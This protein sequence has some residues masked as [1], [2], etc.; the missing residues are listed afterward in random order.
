MAISEAC[1]VIER[2]A[3]IETAFLMHFVNE[4]MPG[5]MDRLRPEQ[6]EHTLRLIAAMS[7]AIDVARKV[8]ALSP[9][10]RELLGVKP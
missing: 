9:V 10:A 2:Q 4:P 5:G 7:I 6:V 8:S 3:Q 1:S